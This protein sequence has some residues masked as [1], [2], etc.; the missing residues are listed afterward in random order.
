VVGGVMIAWKTVACRE[1]NRTFGEAAFDG[2]LFPWWVD[3]LIPNNPYR[4]PAT[5][6]V[7]LAAQVVE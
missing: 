2:C 3:R 5:G 4:S 7:T 6:F 1:S